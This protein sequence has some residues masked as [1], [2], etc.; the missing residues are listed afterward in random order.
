MGSADTTAWHSWLSM[1]KLGEYQKEVLVR[2]VIHRA[3]TEAE[4]T[5]PIPTPHIHPVLPLPARR[6]CLAAI[7]KGPGG[8]KGPIA[9]LLQLAHPPAKLLLLSPRWWAANSGA[10]LSIP[11]TFCGG[12]SVWT[13]RTEGSGR[14]S[15]PTKAP[16]CPT[17]GLHVAGL[18]CSA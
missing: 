6:R 7:L 15:Q 14:S 16:L 17:P 12:T 8:R 18:Q 5:F 11:Q 1:Q 10:Q 13:M 9:A 3:S 2:K 4:A